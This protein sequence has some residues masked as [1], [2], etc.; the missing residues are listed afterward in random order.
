MS[1]RSQNGK[2]LSNICTAERD[3]ERGDSAVVVYI[4]TR[5]WLGW[6]VLW[7][8]AK[9]KKGMFALETCHNDG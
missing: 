4:V 2:P 7:C 6:R 8:G 9:G 1:L 5:V 3:R